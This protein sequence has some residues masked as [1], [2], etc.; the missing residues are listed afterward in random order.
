M[1]RSRLAHAVVL[2]ATL[3]L[4]GPLLAG[5]GA[6]EPGAGADG[7]ESSSIEAP[8]FARTLSEPDTVLVDVRTPAEFERGHVEGA[9]NINVEGE[10]FEERIET[11][12]PD[13]AYA[14]YCRDGR[15]SSRAMRLMAEHGLDHVYELEGGMQAWSAYGGAV[16]RP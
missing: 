14:L 12:D 3:L 13:G 15:R 10:D 6:G 7:T 11:L 1:V 4:A 9:R 5:C 16:T 8:E 2:A